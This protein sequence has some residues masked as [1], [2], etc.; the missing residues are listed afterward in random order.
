MQVTVQKLRAVHLVLSMGYNVILTDGD[1]VWLKDPISYL[2][3]ALV[4]KDAVFMCDSATES[5]EKNR[6]VNTGF[7]I[8]R[9]TAKTV[10]LLHPDR[11]KSILALTERDEGRVL[12]D[13]VNIRSTVALRCY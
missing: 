9:S 5:D 11:V 2:T 1:V 12:N 13:Q 7:Y 3:K 4:G 6:D 8:M 10:Q